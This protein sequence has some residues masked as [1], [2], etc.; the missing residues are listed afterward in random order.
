MSLPRG[1]LRASL[2]QQPVSPMVS[3][4]DLASAESAPQ[5]KRKIFQYKK[6]KK[7]CPFDSFIE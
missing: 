7:K 1:M 2:V 5:L 6:K 3:N 4:P